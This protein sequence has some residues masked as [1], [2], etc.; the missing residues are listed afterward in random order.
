MASAQGAVEILC[1]LL[2]NTNTH[3][4]KKF[5]IQALK[6]RVLNICIS[7]LEVDVITCYY[8]AEYNI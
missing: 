4:K 1:Y 3:N 5:M 2:I 6:S 7:N 8:R